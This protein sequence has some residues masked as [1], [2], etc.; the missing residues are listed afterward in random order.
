MLRDLMYQDRVNRDYGITVPYEAP[1]APTPVPQ[2]LAA[3]E[4]LPPVED[5]LPE[6]EVH[7]PETGEATQTAHIG[8]PALEIWALESQRIREGKDVPAIHRHSNAALR[9]QVR[10]VRCP[11]CG[12]EFAVDSKT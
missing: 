4:Q 8:Q 11:S 5:F 12:L 6:F 9:E 7:A 1:Q 10:E 3:T 2:P